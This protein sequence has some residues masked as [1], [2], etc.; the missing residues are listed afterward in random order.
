MCDE[1][2]EKDN[3]RYLRSKGLKRRDFNRYSMGVALAMM[4]PPIANAMDVVEQDILVE[5]PDGM[6]DSYFVHPEKGTH[7]AVI[8]WPD[9]MGIRT[10]FRMMG[11]RLAQSGYTVL[12]VNP[13]YRSVRGPVIEDGES[14]STPEVRERL[15]PYARSLSP[16]TCVTDGRA[17]VSHLE[18]HPSVD[19]SRKMGTTG[20]CMTGSY[21]L[22]LAAAIPERIGAAASFHGGGLATDAEDSP[23]LLAPQI[24]AGVLIAIAAN[25]D[26][27][28]PDAKDL[29]RKAFDSH[30]VN[31]EVEVYQDTLHGW[32]PPDSVVYNEAQAERAWSRLLALFER[33]L[34]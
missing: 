31:A 3:N 26:E 6:A 27:K 8:I 14:F 5:T 20:Y 15:M 12:V 30:G 24:N 9:I 29:L 1:I 22:R 2:T 11:K 28:D 16:E 33:E 34:G 10:S 19:T 32:C 25:D 7:A 13:Y 23:H 18:K 17:F 21:T 4:L